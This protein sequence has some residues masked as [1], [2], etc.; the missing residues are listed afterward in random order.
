MLGELDAFQ[1]R[2]AQMLGRTLEEL[3]AMSQREYVA[4]QAFA[5]Y[6]AAMRQVAG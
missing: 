6:S 3:G 2:L 1:F 4:W 5:E